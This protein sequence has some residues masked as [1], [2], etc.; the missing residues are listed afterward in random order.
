VIVNVHSGPA[1]SVHVTVVVPTGKNDPDAGVHVI[2]S[3]VPVV[4]GAGYWTTAPHWL[5]SLETV[6][7]DA[8]VG[9]HELSSGGAMYGKDGVATIAASRTVRPFERRL[10]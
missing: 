3:H 4:V 9:T 2:G 5:G 8:H 1:G 6:M 7:F 10:R